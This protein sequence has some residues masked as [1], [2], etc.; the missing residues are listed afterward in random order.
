MGL[1]QLS[2]YTRKALGQELV[3]T[4]PLSGSTPHRLGLNLLAFYLEWYKGAS[5][6]CL[7]F[8]VGMSPSV[9][10]TH[11]LLRGAEG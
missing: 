10:T 2:V 5:F 9:L 3:L 1:V 4:S 8:G 11:T 6:L 7:S